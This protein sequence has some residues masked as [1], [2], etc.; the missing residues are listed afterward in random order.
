MVLLDL[1]L[2]PTND[3]DW[4]MPETSEG[5]EQNHTGRMWQ[6]VKSCGHRLA[7]LIKRY[8]IKCEYLLGCLRPSQNR[9]IVTIFI[10]LF[11]WKWLI[12][13]SF[14]R[15]YCGSTLRKWWYWLHIRIQWQKWRSGFDIFSKNQWRNPG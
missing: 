6:L 9:Y 4:F 10:P 3:G 14:A 8:V 13:V 12:F 2:D 5:R 1:G 11:G 15:C 7:E